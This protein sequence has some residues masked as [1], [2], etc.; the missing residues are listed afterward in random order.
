MANEFERRLGTD[1]GDQ[2]QGSKM[3]PQMD[4]PTSRTMRDAGTTVRE[5]PGTFTTLAL[6]VGAAGFVVGWLCGQSA[7]RS[8]H[9]WR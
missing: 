3:D 8:D 6:V 1:N 4:E 2:L 9:Y 5:N 7:A